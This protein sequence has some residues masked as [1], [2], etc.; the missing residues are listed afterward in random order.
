M[1]LK[2]YIEQAHDGNRSEFA[3]EHGLHL[4]QVWRFLKY[5]SIWWNGRVYKPE[6]GVKNEQ[7]T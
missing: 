2:D 6:T 7:I 3:R 5:E 1:L 4:K